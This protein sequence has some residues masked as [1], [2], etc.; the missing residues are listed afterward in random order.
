MRTRW[1][2]VESLLS[3]G[4]RV[5]YVPEAV[6]AD[7]DAQA[8][9]LAGALGGA[10]G[11]LRAAGAKAN[12]RLADWGGKATESGTKF[13]EQL[14]QWGDQLRTTIPQR[15]GQFVVGQTAHQAVNG[16]E[17]ASIISKGEVI[18]EEHVEQA[19][20]EG[21]LPQLIMAAGAGPV[22]Q[23]TGTLGTQAGENWADMRTEARDLW[24]RL[25]GNV[26]GTYARSV[27]QADDRVMQRRIKHAL[28]RP[29]TRV[30]L[31]EDDNVIL[32]TGDIITNRAM[33]AAREAGVLDV[34]VA[35]VYDERPALGLDHFRTSANGQASLERLTAGASPARTNKI[36]NAVAQGTEA[37]PIEESQPLPDP[38]Y[39]P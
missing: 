23:H 9:N 22:R 30:I 33:R 29:T 2:P 3:I 21:R 12:E 25:T 6:A 28:G 18:T 39:R 11:R 16:P 4:Q 17:G 10:G 35:S 20:T 7:F 31:D 5:M 19:K 26:T 1:L 14:G 15:V 37:L 36:G 38:A 32:N 24:G 8:A 27:D 13:N 34:L